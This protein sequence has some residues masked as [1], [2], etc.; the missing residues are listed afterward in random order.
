MG[1]PKELLQYDVVKDTPSMKL[2]I[3]IPIYNERTLVERSLRAMGEKAPSNPGRGSLE[4]RRSL[5][6]WSEPVSD[7]AHPT[8]AALKV[9]L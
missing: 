3:L 8:P 2:S 5:Q 6:A 9:F 1:S 7:S 4:A